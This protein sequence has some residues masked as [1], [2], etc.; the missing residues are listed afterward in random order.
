MAKKEFTTTSKILMYLLA[1]EEV[2]VDL[3]PSRLKHKALYGLDIKKDRRM[4]RYL[5]DKGWIKKVDKNSEK[6][7]QL[8]QKG[9]LEALLAKA[10]L[11]HQGKWDGKWRMVIFDIPEDHKDKRN[12]L[13]LLLKKNNFYMLQAS[14]YVSPHAFNR[15]AVTYLQE[16]KLSPYIRIIK[17]EEMDNDTDLK[18]HFHLK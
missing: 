17:V 2:A 12:L 4:L 14:V 15:E 9:E 5:H 11:P 1:A 8:T 18:K 3:Y 7:Y 13:R 6:F 10:K 16:T